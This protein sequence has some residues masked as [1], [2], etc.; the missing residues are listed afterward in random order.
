MT[1]SYRVFVHLVDEAG[2]IIVQSDAEPAG[3]QRPTTGWAVGEY[4]VDQHVLQLPDDHLP[5]GLQLRIGL[6]ETQSGDR[7]P[8][9]DGDAFLA[10]LDN[11]QD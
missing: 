4:I 9:G 2:Q 5:Q 3:W 7:L 10:P 6:Y 8:A 11:W 1:D